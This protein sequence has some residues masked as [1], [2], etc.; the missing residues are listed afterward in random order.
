MNKTIIIAVG[1]VVAGGVVAA[2]LFLFVFS[3]GSEAVGEPTPEPTPIVVEGKLGP[4]L[5]IGSRVF[6]L[7]PGPNGSS[8]YLKLAVVIE[9]ETT[10][11]DWAWVLHGCVAVPS[12]GG[13]SV[14]KT[15]EERLLHEFQE[16]IGSGLTLIEDAVTTIVSSKTLEQVSTP[17]GKAHLREEILK[18]VH[19]AIPEP[20]AT[21][22]LFTDFVTQ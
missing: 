6:N 15:E 18:A 5:I 8:A 17:E 13:G 1:G 4:R 3:G 16:E 20:H 10:S 9:F 11:E 2:V 22:V 19:H 12:G 7:A 21:R 14:C